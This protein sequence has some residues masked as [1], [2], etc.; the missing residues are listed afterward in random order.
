[1][2]AGNVAVRL[3]PFIVTFDRA[4][5]LW[6]LATLPKHPEN[7]PINMLVR[8]EGTP[9]ADQEADIRMFAKPG[10]QPMAAG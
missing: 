1:L 3:A 2:Q 9:S 8:V 10:L 6:V 4:H 7:V 5:M